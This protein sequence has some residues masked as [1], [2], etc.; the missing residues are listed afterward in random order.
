MHKGDLV[1]PRIGRGCASVLS[2]DC[3]A[4][5]RLDEASEPRRAWSVL[6]PNTV[7]LR[8]GRGPA[9]ERSVVLELDGYE[10]LDLEYGLLRL[11]RL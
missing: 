9:R 1:A 8:S 3:V 6:A 11:L 10:T 4:M 2:V 5:F 7:R